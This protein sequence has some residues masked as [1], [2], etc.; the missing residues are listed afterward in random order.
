MSNPAP[1]ATPAAATSSAFTP[2]GATH[3]ALV[4]AD[5]GPELA[6]QVA[7]F[8]A[9]HDAL[10]ARIAGETFTVLHRIDAHVFDFNED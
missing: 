7:A 10:L 1:A 2:N 4:E 9:E 8:D 5:H 6:H 3:M